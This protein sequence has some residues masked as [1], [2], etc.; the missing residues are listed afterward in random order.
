MGMTSPPAVTIK[1]GADGSD[2][3]LLIVMDNDSAFLPIRS[4]SDVTLPSSAHLRQRRLSLRQP[5]GHVHGAVQRDGGGQFSTSLL[6]PA[7][8]GIQRAEAEVA[9]GLERVHCQL[10][11]KAEGLA[12]V[13]LSR[14]DRRRIEMR[15][16]FAQEPEGPC[17]V[18]SFFMSTSELDGLQR[19]RVRVLEVASQQIAL[20]QQGHLE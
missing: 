12:V 14:L 5:E 6:S 9:V 20:T 8:R 18:S 17:L 11:G 16:D 19:A 13:L 7:S 4:V 2:G 3:M 10:V 1:S 15:M